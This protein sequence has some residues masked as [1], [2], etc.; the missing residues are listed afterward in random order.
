MAVEENMWNRLLGSPYAHIVSA[1]VL[2]AGLAAIL[3]A[4][5]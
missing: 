3:L 2:T 5:R 1:I 4:G